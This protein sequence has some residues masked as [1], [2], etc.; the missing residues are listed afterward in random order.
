MLFLNESTAVFDP[1]NNR[2]QILS[3]V[4]WFVALS[5]D[6]RLSPVKKLGLRIDKLFSDYHFDICYVTI[7][8]EIK[9]KEQQAVKF[10]S[11]RETDGY[12]LFFFEWAQ[13][14]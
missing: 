14:I 2:I 10:V 11:S 7:S 3:N 13:D 5:V 4:S 6:I 12:R 1:S 8:P 9:I